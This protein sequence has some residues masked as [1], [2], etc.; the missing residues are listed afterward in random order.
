MQRSS[1]C[2]ALLASRAELE[3]VSHRGQLP[4]LQSLPLPFRTQKRRGYLL[5][6]QMEIEEA[7]G[8]RGEGDECIALSVSV[9]A[10]H[11]LSVT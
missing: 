5:P 11:C 7:R 9:S 3:Y 1:T 4:G 2:V 10:L 8:R 6:T